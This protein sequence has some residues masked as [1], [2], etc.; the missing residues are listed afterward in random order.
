MKSS[1]YIT[2]IFVTDNHVG[3]FCL[4]KKDNAKNLSKN[5]FLEEGVISNGYIQDPN[6]LY[7]SLKAGFKELKLIPK[8]LHFVFL[9]ENILI[10]ELSV[11]KT[12]L[13]KMDMSEY[14]QSQIG[15]SIHFPFY[16]GTFSYQIKNETDEAYTIIVYI[17]DQNLIEDYLD[18]LEKTGV[19]ETVINL[20]ASNI[21]TLYNDD[22]N[23]ILKNSMIVCVLENNI[24]IHIIEDRMTVFGMNDECDATSQEKMCN[25]VE[26][27]IERIANYYQYNLRQGKKKIENIILINLS[28]DI[29]DHSIAE[30]LKK[31]DF[32]IKTILL[33]IS[34]INPELNP[35]DKYSNVAYI[36]SS[37]RL[38]NNIPILDFKI[39][40]QRSSLII[41]SYLLVLSILIFSLVSLVYVPWAN[42]N[43]E[44]EQL[45]NINNSLTIQKE[46][47]E[48]NIVI[49]QS[50]SNYE[51][52]Y[53][54]A[55]DYLDQVSISHTSYLTDLFSY[56]T[57]DVAIIDININDSQKS[58]TLILTSDDQAKLYEYAISTYE[59]FGVL[60]VASDARWMLYEPQTTIIANN[61]MRVVIYY[62]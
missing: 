13:Q 50:L 15:V 20:L 18:I 55:F 14:I 40:R 45:E 43:I 35:E 54:S 49:A 28:R 3:I 36:S 38:S 61:T 7:K 39:K 51:R 48:E 31:Y 23:N 52:G 60:S 34:N 30:D 59:E 16:S 21:N 10:R 42:M 11:S 9:G 26:E 27:Y 46:M 22:Q 17:A 57:A 62:A 12:S 53:N 8:K 2:S 32:G 1:D 19:K 47:L 37:S 33:N 4:N 6:E 25:Q 5:I 41:A 44:I 58:I 56:T 24:T 29:A